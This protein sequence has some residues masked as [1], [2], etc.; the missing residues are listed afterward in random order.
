MAAHDS[1][2]DLGLA[3]GERLLWSGR[4]AYGISARR[5]R[6]TGLFFFLTWTAFAIF[7]TVKVWQAVDSPEPDLSWLFPLVGIAF[8]LVGGVQFARLVVNP[9]GAQDRLFAV[10]D[11]RVIIAGIGVLGRAESLGFDRM[12]EPRLELHADGLG[13]ISFPELPGALRLR[14]ARTRQL[15]FTS[16]AQP[17]TVF[18]L[19][20]AA[21][22]GTVPDAPPVVPQ[23]AASPLPKIPRTSPRR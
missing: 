15:A 9:Q 16:I 20:R 14:G 11:R 2:T 5:R 21:R 12:I 6:T 23:P 10:S 13:D 4:P 22:T 17:A 3:P 7:W 19:I 1:P 18:D 8:A